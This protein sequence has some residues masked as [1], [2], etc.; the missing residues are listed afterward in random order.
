MKWL[1][2][3]FC[4]LPMPWYPLMLIILLFIWMEFT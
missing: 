3:K 2:R 4:E 1:W